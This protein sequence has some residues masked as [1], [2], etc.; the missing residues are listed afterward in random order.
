MNTHKKIHDLLEVAC[1][2]VNEAEQLLDRDIQSRVGYTES[3][4]QDLEYARDT[5]ERIITKI[6]DHLNDQQ[7][8]E[9]MRYASERPEYQSS[10]SIHA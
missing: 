6:W 2:M 9:R 1:T 8:I 3:Q 4:I 10:E 7:K 5:I